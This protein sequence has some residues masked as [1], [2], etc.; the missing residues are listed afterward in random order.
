MRVLMLCFYLRWKGASIYSGDMTS[1]RQDVA[2]TT[3]ALIQKKKLRPKTRR[4]AP[5]PLE[6][7]LD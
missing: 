2:L 1:S 4:E 3:R 6:V 7:L 5:R